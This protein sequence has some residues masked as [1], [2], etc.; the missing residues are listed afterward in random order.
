[1]NEFKFEIDFI[2]KKKKKNAN[3]M[4]KYSQYEFVLR[5]KAQWDVR[6]LYIQFRRGDGISLMDFCECRINIFLYL[7]SCFECVSGIS[8][9]DIF[10]KNST[11]LFFSIVRLVAI[12]KD[13]VIWISVET[14]NKWD[15][16][17]LVKFIMTSGG[18]V[19]R[20]PSLHERIGVTVLILIL[21]FD[22]TPPPNNHKWGLF[23]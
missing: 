18:T 11:Y 1:M 16:K 5:G 6:V 14:Y 15:D 23:W 22:A 21:W 17:M 12:K 13:Q 7:Q 2:Y 20:C 8:R 3:Q 9:N 10:L 19:L 4:A